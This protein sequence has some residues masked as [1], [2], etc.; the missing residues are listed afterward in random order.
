VRQRGLSPLILRTRNTHRA[1][2]VELPDGTP[3][4][5]RV[6]AEEARTAKNRI[7]FNLGPTGVERGELDP[8]DDRVEA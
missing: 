7:H 5:L 6:R 1:R 2:N 3:G 8:V 4:L